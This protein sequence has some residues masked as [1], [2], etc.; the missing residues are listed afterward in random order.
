MENGTKFTHEFGDIDERFYNSIE[1]ALQELATLLRGEARGLYPQFASRL[2][3]VMELSDGIG[4]GFHDFV[5]DVI[6]A[7]AQDPGGGV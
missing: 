7:L 3:K 2:T 4:W 1:S 6:G 5:S